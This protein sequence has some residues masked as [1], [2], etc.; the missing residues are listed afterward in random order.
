[1]RI[2]FLFL[3]PAFALSQTIA[4]EP[5]TEKDFPGSVTFKA[6]TSEYTVALTGLSVRKYFF[7][8]YE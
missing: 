2:L 1:M 4:K 3:L 7:K 8:V 6:G 5:S